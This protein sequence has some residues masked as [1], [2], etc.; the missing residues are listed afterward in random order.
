MIPAQP[1]IDNRKKEITLK[2]D[3][4]YKLHYHNVIKRR[5]ELEAIV[6]HLFG[7]DYKVNFYGPDGLK[8]LATFDLPDFNPFKKDDEDDEDLP[9]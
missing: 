4:E 7:S 1:I 6:F 3:S 2:Y 5:R 9:F 8:D